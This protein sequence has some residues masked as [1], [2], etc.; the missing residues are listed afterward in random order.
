[1]SQPLSDSPAAKRPGGRVPL[2]I[3]MGLVAVLV[4]GLIAWTQLRTDAPTAADLDAATAEL[5]ADIQVEADDVEDTTTTAADEA[6]DETEAAETS[7]DTTG[8]PEADEAAVTVDAV[9]GDWTVDTSIGEFSFENSTG[10]YVGFRIGEELATVGKT[11][12]VGRTPAVSGTITIDGQTVTATSIEADMTAITTDIRQRDGAARRA[13]DT[14]N[15][16]TATFVLTEPI[17]LGSDPASGEPVSATAVGDLTIHG[18]TNP[19]EVAIDA[20]LVGDTIAVVG[21]TDVVFADYGVN[22]PS[23]RVV[24]SLDDFGI[25]EFQLFLTRS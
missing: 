11:E 14:N 21:S 12:A 20:Q 25:I 13:L 16:P 15:F 24:V 8:E 23:A 17:D 2:Y 19:V 18:V 5:A 1:M 10:T 22:A 4:L 7:E 3:G 9:S 6:T